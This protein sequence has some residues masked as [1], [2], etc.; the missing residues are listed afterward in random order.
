MVRTGRGQAHLSRRG[1]GGETSH[2]R[3]HRLP[4][5]LQGNQNSG[6]SHYVHLYK[7]S[8]TSEI[9]ERLQNNTGEPYLR[10]PFDHSTAWS[11][12]HSYRRR[13]PCGCRSLAGREHTPETPDA[14]SCC[15][16]L[17]Y[18]TTYTAGQRQSVSLQ[19]S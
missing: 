17:I 15:Q 3:R 1:R 10:Q 11:E 4:C 12:P 2:Q 13:T 5:S 8:Q 9:V 6:L 16:G 18:T 14:R 19:I 7:E